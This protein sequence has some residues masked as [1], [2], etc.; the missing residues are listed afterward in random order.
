VKVGCDKISWSPHDPTAPSPPQNLG[1]CPQT[2]GLTP[3]LCE[4]RVAMLA[5]LCSGVQLLPLL[6][7]M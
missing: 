1:S 5:E 3:M 6:A 7:A 4:L 2:P